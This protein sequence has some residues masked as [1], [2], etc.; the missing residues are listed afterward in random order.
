VALTFL[1][2][3]ALDANTRLLTSPKN[4]IEGFNKMSEPKESTF[5]KNMQNH[6]KISNILTGLG[7]EVSGQCVIDN[8]LPNHC[9]RVVCES[10][11]LIYCSNKEDFLRKNPVIKSWMD[12]R[13]SM[14]EK[15]NLKQQ[16][17]HEWAN[18]PA[19]RML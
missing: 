5:K 8:T 9:F 11:P 2:L 13:K 10:K 17:A 18:R 19:E 12:S 15:Y 14:V 7:F 1:T 3:K 16:E 4:S 6:K